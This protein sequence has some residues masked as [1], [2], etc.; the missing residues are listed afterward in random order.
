MLKKVLKYLKQKGYIL[1]IAS[2]TNDHTIENYKNDNQNIINKANIEDI[3]SLVYS[4]GAVKEL[5]P[6]PEIHYKILKELN[7][8]KKECL[9]VLAKENY[10]KEKI[11]DFNVEMNINTDSSIDITE[12][13]SINATE[14]LKEYVVKDLFQ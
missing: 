6:N 3:F 10:K 14:N 8:D 11:V 1:V 13:F 5:K 9:I 7:V 12:S 2:T 4:K